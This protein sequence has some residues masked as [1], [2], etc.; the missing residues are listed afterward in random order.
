MLVKEFVDGYNN[1]KKPELKRDFCEKHLTKKYA[2]IVQKNAVL[3]NFADGCVRT[4][5]NGITYI[6][7]V[8]NKMNMTWAIVF[9]YTDLTLDEVEEKLPDGKTKK[10]QDVIGLYDKFQEYGILNMFCDLIGERE[11]GE[12]LMVNS[13]VL[14]TWHEE[15]SSSRAFM[16]EM[17]DKAVRTFVEMAALMKEVVTPEDQ[18]KLSETVKGFVGIS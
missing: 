12:L 4:N 5:E 6:D 1:L 13:E 10:S 3:K 11:I 17:V 2:S 18:E 8:A 14:D 15:H 7:M 9:L 16:S